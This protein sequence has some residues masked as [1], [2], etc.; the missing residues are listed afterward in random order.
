L[1]TSI[2]N[3]L[4]DYGLQHKL[5]GMIFLSFLIHL[6]FVSFLFYMPGFKKME[7]MSP[8]VISVDIVSL[9][10]SVPSFGLAGD[11]RKNESKKPVAK[12]VIQ[13]KQ[14]EPEKK[15]TYKKDKKEKK[16][17]EKSKAKKKVATAPVKSNDEEMER[18][19]EKIR[20]GLLAKK[21]DESSV[22]GKG[23]TG[24]GY[25][26]QGVTSQGSIDLRFQ[27]YYGLIWSKIKDAWVLPENMT[28]SGKNLEAI[29]A[30]RIRKDGEIVKAWVE[31]SSG[32]TYFD[33]S[34]LRA[35]SKANPLPPVPE[36]YS[37]EYFELGIR[38][39]PSE[40]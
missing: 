8:A 39:F 34:A 17:G 27:I 1:I 20:Q 33:Q 30:I 6:A 4:E 11:V 31:K 14:P 3:N 24:L 26:K 25:S 18:A 28:S 23:G 10:R 35:V 37:E 9:Q 38:F 32:N 16:V 7:I 29:I 15:M 2:K 22:A 40:L 12:E 5:A 19:I 13:L 36:G 21:G